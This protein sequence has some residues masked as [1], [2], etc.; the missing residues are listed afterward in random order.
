[1]ILFSVL[2]L[3]VGAQRYVPRRVVFRVGPGP[4]P[5]ALP[6]SSYVSLCGPLCALFDLSLCGG[7][8]GRS[9]SSRL[10]YLVPYRLVVWADS[11]RRLSTARVLYHLAACTGRFRLLLL[12]GLGLLYAGVSF[13]AS[14]CS[15]GGNKI[16]V[17]SEY[18]E[19]L[20]SSSYRP[21]R[22]SRTGGGGPP[23]PPTPVCAVG[24]NARD[25]FSFAFLFFRCSPGA[26]YEVPPPSPLLWP[27]EVATPIAAPGRLS[28]V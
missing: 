8:A 5:C 4:L 12:A 9:G 26:R 16:S 24:R 6:Y 27:A 11:L 19:P 28:V 14:F 20:S 17:D 2:R 21:D 25:L 15:S 23:P 13:Q 22:S 7:P 3:F 10:H 1:V 18:S